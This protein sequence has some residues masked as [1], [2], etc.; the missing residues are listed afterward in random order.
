MSNTPISRPPVG[1]AARDMPLNLRMI[2]HEREGEL[3]EGRQLVAMRWVL[4]WVFVAILIA[5]A[6]VTLAVV[7]FGVGTT[8]TVERKMLLGVSIVQVITAMIALFYSLFGIR[9]ETQTSASDGFAVKETPRDSAV[10]TT[11]DLELERLRTEVSSLTALPDRVIG[12]LA[13]GRALSFKVLQSKLSIQQDDR[14]QTAGL[15]ACLGEL[16]T[17]GIIEHNFGSVEDYTLSKEWLRRKERT[18]KRAEPRVRR[19]AGE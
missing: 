13:A 18:D 8:D 15:Q 1:A 9:R 3:A 12:L 4:F 6:C 19:V 2:R 16:V 5:T 11:P 14:E 17:R 10:S 7:L